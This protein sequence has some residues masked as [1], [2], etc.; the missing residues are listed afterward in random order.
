[1]AWYLALAF[2]AS[3]I[4]LAGWVGYRLR[5][6]V[7]VQASRKRHEQNANLAHLAQRMIDSSGYLGGDLKIVETPTGTRVVRAY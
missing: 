7:E 1:M 6:G 3:S 2:M 4:P 5:I